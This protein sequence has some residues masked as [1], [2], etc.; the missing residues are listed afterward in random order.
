VT[1]GQGG[2]AASGAV[3]RY[4]LARCDGFEVWSEDGRLSGVIDGVELDPAGR[5]STLLVHRRGRRPL[6]VGRSSVTAVYPWQ[7]LV[8]V[9]PPERNPRTARA[10]HAASGTAARGGQAAWSGATRGGQAALTGATR[11]GQAAGA[12]AAR[13]GAVS[14]A[15]AATAR[16]ALPPARRL[17]RRVGARAAY[18]LAIAGWLYG[19]VVFTVS[20]VVV[21]A[22]L[23]TLSGVARVSVRAAPPIA[24]SARKATRKA[25]QPLSGPR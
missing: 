21:R 13:A 23:V 6:E 5:A 25:L 9:A 8:V 15:A 17:A 19:F 20:R 11:G 1:G 12:A 22:L 18:L 10:V 7:R 14:V 16:R 24:H 4:W 2:F 3:G